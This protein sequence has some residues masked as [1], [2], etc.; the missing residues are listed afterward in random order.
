MTAGSPGASDLYVNVD[1]QEIYT[2][3][4][5]AGACDEDTVHLRDSDSH[6]QVA[7]FRAVGDRN[8]GVV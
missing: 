2:R 7:T 5:C 8:V 4:R 6:A 3:A 1:T